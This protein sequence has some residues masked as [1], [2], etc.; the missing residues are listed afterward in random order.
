[1][2]KT[3][4]FIDSVAKLETGSA[5]S[6]G[7]FEEIILKAR[8]AREELDHIESKLIPCGSWQ[9]QNN[10][11]ELFKI[12]MDENKN[13]GITVYF[14]DGILARIIMSKKE[15]DEMVDSLEYMRQSIKKK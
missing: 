3:K 1:M 12:S 11:G 2:K 9:I 4:K 15:F 14:N 13:P 10:A 7:L 5:P 6:V 8:E